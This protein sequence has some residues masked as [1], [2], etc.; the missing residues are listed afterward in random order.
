[1]ISS[2][3]APPDHRRVVRLTHWVNTLSFVALVVSGVAILIARPRLYWGDVGNDEMPAAFELPQAVDLN[4]S[5]WG[6][7]L[8]F[9]GAGSPC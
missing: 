6:R 1:M 4:H 2:K 7:S 5:G 3:P 9:L 8:H